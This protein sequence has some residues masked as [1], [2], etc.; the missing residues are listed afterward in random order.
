M[1]KHILGY[2]KTILAA[3]L[4]ALIVYSF[5][6]TLADFNVARCIADGDDS[7]FN[8]MPQLLLR[9]VGAVGFAVAVALFGMELMK[10]YLNSQIPLKHATYNVDNGVL[11]MFF[12]KP[13][14][15]S[16]RQR[17]VLMPNTY[18][19]PEGETAVELDAPGKL[20]TGGNVNGHKMKLAVSDTVRNQMAKML[21]SDSNASIDLVICP[22]SIRTT[23]PLPHDI[24]HHNNGDPLLVSDIEVIRES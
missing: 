17:L 12:S 16:N 2:S 5:F 24:T 18:I 22:N 3:A 20:A 4:V 10:R 7:L 23:G 6:E 14:V 13:T 8:C 1:A 9:M 11:T 15:L 19:H 21:K